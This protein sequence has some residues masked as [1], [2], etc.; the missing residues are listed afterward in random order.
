MTGTI[1]LTEAEACEAVRAYLVLRGALPKHGVVRKVTGET[2]NNYNSSRGIEAEVEIGDEP[3]SQP[4][5]ETATVP[6]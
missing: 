4:A 3:A 5:P 1:T 2:T 6:S